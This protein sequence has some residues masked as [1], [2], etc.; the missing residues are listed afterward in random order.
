M[1]SGPLLSLQSFTFTPTLICT[2]GELLW[3]SQATINYAINLFF[4]DA[5]S[6]TNTPPA[7]AWSRRPPFP[8]SQV[9]KFATIGHGGTTA[10]QPSVR[11]T[12]SVWRARAH[13]S[14]P[15][16]ASSASFPSL[17]V[18][19]NPLL[20]PPQAFS[21]F[22]KPDCPSF[23]VHQPLLPAYPPR[24]PSAWFHRLLPVP[25][26]FTLGFRNSLVLMPSLFVSRFLHTLSS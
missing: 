8:P 23:R 6:K 19:W 14:K 10:L 13:I 5:N 20:K 24:R 7:P 9:T 22:L 25:S 2:M 1:V 4:T 16:P 26:S 18:A 11:S 17:L 21:S 3:P 12:T 15:Y